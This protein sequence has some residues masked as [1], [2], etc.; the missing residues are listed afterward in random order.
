MRTFSSTV[1]PG[2][3]LVLWYERAM[4]LREI[5]FG[6]SPAMSSPANRMRPALGF[7]TPVTQ[8]K[9]VDLPAPLGPMM[10]RTSPAGTAMLTSLSAVRPPNRMVSFSVRRRGAAPAPAT[11]AARSI[12]VPV[13]LDELAGGRHDRLLFRDRLADVVLAV[14]Y[15]EDELADERLVVLFP[16]GLVA[17]WG[18]VAFLHLP[19]LES[20]DE[21]HRV[22]VASEAALLHAD[23]ERVHRLEVRLHVAIRQGARRVDLLERRHRL[24][25]E[26]LVR[27]RVQRRV[28]PRG[29]PVGV[30]QAP[31]LLRGGRGIGGDPQL[32]RPR[33][34]LLLGAGR[35]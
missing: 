23:L 26:L 24:V 18:V 7:S 4:A 3:M 6:G 8:L 35:A 33:R 22:L 17:L 30:R 32:R 25:E 12:C 21:L 13:T 10:A 5:R 34:P 11:G 16:H 1:A 20:F 28:Q 9:N 31:P 27:R 2:R 15:V 19:A 29:A 14:L